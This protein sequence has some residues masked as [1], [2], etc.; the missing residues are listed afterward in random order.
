MGLSWLGRTSICRGGYL[1]W[2]LA[3]FESGPRLGDDVAGRDGSVA[4]SSRAQILIGTLSIQIIRLNWSQ[5]KA[6]V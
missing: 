5:E 4:L 1:N 2:M 6:S 3:C